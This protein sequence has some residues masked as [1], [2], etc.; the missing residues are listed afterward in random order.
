MDPG[1]LLEL[2]G[3]ELRHRALGVLAGAVVE[4]DLTLLA[5]GVQESTLTVVAVV[6]LGRVDRLLNPALGGL[7]TVEVT[8]AV[9]GHVGVTGVPAGPAGL[10]RV[11]HVGVAT[12]HTLDEGLLVD[13]AA[14]AL[15]ELLAAEQVAR[16]GVPSVL[17]HVVHT[18]LVVRLRDEVHRDAV[19]AVE[20][21]DTLGRH[22]RHVGLAGLE[23][24]EAGRLLLNDPALEG[25]EVG[26]VLE[27][28]VDVRRLLHVVVL[29]TGVRLPA[30]AVPLLEGVGAEVP[31]ELEVEQLLILL[32][33][34]LVL[35]LHVRLEE[36]L[37]DRVHQR[38]VRRR[39]EQV[40]ALEGDLELELA[41][42]LDRRRFGPRGRGRRR[43]PL[44][45]VNLVDEVDEVL[46]GDL[47]VV[48]AELEVLPDR[49]GPGLP[50]VVGR[51]LVELRDLFVTGTERV[52][53]VERVAD[54]GTCARFG[55]VERVEGVDRAAGNSVVR[56]TD[57]GD[58]D[59][60]LGRGRVF[61]HRVPLRVGRGVGCRFGAVTAGTAGHPGCAGDAEGLKPLAPVDTWVR[62]I[63]TSSVRVRHVIRLLS[64]VPDKPVD[65][66]HGLFT[67]GNRKQESANARRS[68]M[69]MSGRRSYRP[70][71]H[72]ATAGVTP[73]R[74]FKATPTS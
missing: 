59:L 50:A 33:S 27:H 72:R 25:L 34:L 40:R 46:G 48:G 38:V 57:L 62:V 6:V 28:L 67:H 55:V 66:Y 51:Q 71:D 32:E 73:D 22:A 1:V 5:R 7:L 31:G 36:V 49:P 17:P 69:H 43:R 63:S 20:L 52:P 53:H 58:V 8:G 29:V 26:S 4:A 10:P 18:D 12:E 37:R 64:D 24:A 3:D 74:G 44:G 19:H 9:L 30:G 15:A 13:R 14:E 56:A 21:L 47:A 61:A 11:L 2:L 68:L 35:V 70:S 41:G 16:T 60:A 23:G 39:V 54:Q 42:L 65:W 45:L